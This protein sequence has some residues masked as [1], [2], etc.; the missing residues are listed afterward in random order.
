MSSKSS[1]ALLGQP[2]LLRAL[3]ELGAF[4]LD[5]VVLLLA[6]VLD[7]RVGVAE[8]DAAQA[9]HDLHDLFLVHHDAVRLG[10]VR[11]TISWTLRDLLGAVLAP[12]VVGDQVHRARAEEGVGGDEVLEPVGLHL[13]EQPPHAAG[14][15]L[16]HARRVAAAEH[17][18]DRWSS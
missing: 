13:D 4:L 12:V 17:L 9:V 11:S 7:E 5:L 18:E 14:F 16:E 1:S 3:D 6:D 15:K 2:L 8:L 10:G